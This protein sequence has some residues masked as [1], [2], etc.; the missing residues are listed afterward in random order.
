LLHT[1]FP[2]LEEDRLPEEKSARVESRRRIASAIGDHLALALSNLKLRDRLRDLSVRDPLT[3]LFNRRYLEET[4]N[5]ETRNAKRRGETLGIIMMDVD[6]FKDFNDTFGHEAGDRVL[7]SL[8][9]ILLRGI[10]GGDVACRYGGEEFVVIMPG[11]SLKATKNRAEILRKIAE[12]NLR[13]ANVDDR[14]VTVSCGVAVFPGHG[15]D[16]SQVLNA[17]DTAMYRAKE[18]GRN[19][20]EMAG[21]NGPLTAQT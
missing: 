1:E 6:H 18:Q 16:P 10:R 14:T 9:K 19:R 4:L 15:S 13:E 3:G 5:R 8:G 21:E 20:V 11:A 17:A 7:K 12:R 2:F